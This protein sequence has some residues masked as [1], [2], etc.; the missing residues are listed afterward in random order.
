MYYYSTIRLILIDHPS[1]GRRLSRPRHCS[2]CAARAAYRS[3]FF[4]KTQ[5]FVRSAIRTWALA[6]QESGL[7]LDHWDRLASTVLTEHNYCQALQ[8]AH[9]ERIKR[10]AGW[11]L[12]DG[13][14]CVGGLSKV[15]HAFHA[16][17]LPIPI[18]EDTTSQPLKA[19][20]K[21]RAWQRSSPNIFEIW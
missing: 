8:T 6:Q 15:Y 16:V 11:V 18:I 20:K 14:E 7:P 2:Q 9:I 1:E 3:D 4:V 5:T 21:D 12:R 13:S 17:F 10:H 19:W